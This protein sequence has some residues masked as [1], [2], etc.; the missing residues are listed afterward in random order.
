MSKKI[1]RVGYV[2]DKS[3]YLGATE[4]SNLSLFT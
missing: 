2:E 1:I 3:S 4:E